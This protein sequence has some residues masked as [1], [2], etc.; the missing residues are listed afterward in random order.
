M[1]EEEALE[2]PLLATPSSPK[3]LLLEEVNNATTCADRLDAEEQQLKGETS[4]PCLR[5]A[6]NTVLDDTGTEEN[7]NRQKRKSL[8]TSLWHLY[9]N[10][11]N[12]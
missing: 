7:N 5:T 9:I 3:H 11:M 1:V 8:R 12:C 4:F 6:R 2:M 10:R